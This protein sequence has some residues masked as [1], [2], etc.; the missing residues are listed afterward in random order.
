MVRGKPNEAVN[1]LADN[2]EQARAYACIELD[3]EY[4][5]VAA[6]RDKGFEEYVSNHDDTP[7]W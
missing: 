5:D 1:I 3:C 6:Y 4:I 2:R 7:P